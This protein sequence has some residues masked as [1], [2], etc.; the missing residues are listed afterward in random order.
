MA[1][2]LDT[3]IRWSIRRRVTLLVV[4]AMVFA[5]GLYVTSTAPLD[6]LPD[7]TPPR[8]VIQTEAPGMGTADIEE[9]VT[10]P[11]EHALLGTPHVSSIRSSSIPGLSAITMMFD[12]DVDLFRTR[13]LVAE[14]LQLASAA[15][16]AAVEAPQLE[17]I[18]PPIGSLLKVCV[19]GADPRAL[20][21]LR[22]FADWTM[23]PRLAG[24][25]GIAQV[26]VHGGLVERLEI[27]PDPLRMRAHAVSLDD[28]VR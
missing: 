13:Q 7:F 20:T 21:R 4:A 26:I 8:V 11:L 1:S 5:A 22:S 24:I 12:D 14:R 15:L 9:R 28:I 10:W 3:L 18:Q 19:T 2:P 27:R 16:P 17:P 25:P 6:V 23:R